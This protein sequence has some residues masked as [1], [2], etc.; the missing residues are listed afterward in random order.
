VD[1]GQFT[2]AG[3]LK[4]FDPSRFAKLPAARL[5]AEFDAQGSR[6]PQLALG[7]RFQLRN[8]RLGGEALA[9]RGEIDLAGERLRKADIELAAAGN[10]LSAKGAFG[11]PGDR[12]TVSI[13]APKL[14]LLGVAGDLAGVVVVGGG[15]KTLQLSA[16]LHSTRLAAAGIGQL[17][18]WTSKLSSAT[19]V[20]VR[21][22]ASCDWP[23]WTCLA[24]KPSPRTCSS[25]PRVFAA[26]TVY[27]GSWL[28]PA[29]V[30]FACCSRVAS[31]RRR[32]A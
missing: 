25:M 15:L 8:S 24:A 2:V 18:G 11:A 22:S 19:A 10:Q 1:T 28:C 13:A 16:D 7:L 21:W 30:V 27:A 32:P 23:D 29:S 9:G 14:D 17:R 4:D 6:Q 5:N 12:L 3:S 26:S 31:P 20:R